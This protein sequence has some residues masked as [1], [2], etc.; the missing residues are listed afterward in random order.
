MERTDEG[1]LLRVTEFSACMDLPLGEKK[2][3]REK[4][5]NPKK[6]SIWTKHFFY[7]KPETEL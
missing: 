4:K 1:G 7:L 2:K 6:L 3:R 5:R